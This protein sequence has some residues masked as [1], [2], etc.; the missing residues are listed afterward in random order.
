MMGAPTLGSWMSQRGHSETVQCPRRL[1]LGGCHKDNPAPLAFG[2]R[3]ARVD[4]GVVAIRLREDP[5][6]GSG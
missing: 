3:L 2:G 4:R 1:W 6:R 5:S